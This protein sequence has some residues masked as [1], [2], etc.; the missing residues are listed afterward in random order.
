MQVLVTKKSR[1]P[2]ADSFCK[3][4]KVFRAVSVLHGP[5]ACSPRKK[6]AEAAEGPP[7]DDGYTGECSGVEDDGGGG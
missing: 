5:P 4:G 2:A 3:G 7:V 1:R 6:N